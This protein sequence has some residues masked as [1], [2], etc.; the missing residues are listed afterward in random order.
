MENNKEKQKKTKKH[1]DKEE[2]LSDLLESRI[3][4]D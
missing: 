2:K 1:D 3:Y 4:S